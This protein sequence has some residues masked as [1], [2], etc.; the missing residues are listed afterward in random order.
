MGNANEGK[1]TM[2][3]KILA[4]LGADLQGETALKKQSL[5]QVFLL[6]KASPCANLVLAQKFI[7]CAEYLDAYT[8][9][10]D[11][12][13]QIEKGMDAVDGE[14]I[15]E[16]LAKAKTLLGRMC[17]SEI[18]ELSDKKLARRYIEEAASELNWMPAVSDLLAMGM[19][20][21][22]RKKYEEL[23]YMGA[24]N[25]RKGDFYMCLQ[26]VDAFQNL[27]QG[28][29]A[30]VSLSAAL[31]QLTQLPAA[32]Q[33]DAWNA[34]CGLNVKSPETREAINFSYLLAG[35]M[36]GDLGKTYAVCSTGAITKE[37]LATLREQA[38]QNGR[39]DQLDCINA[40]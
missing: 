19:P 8:L 20:A 16:V 30:D 27:K 23:F 28:L 40:R 14:N 3:D 7:E 38:T 21:E 33:G 13:A 29:Q 18:L 9:L 4:N 17:N 39:T 12:C 2:M 1:D 31:M 11:L 24:V 6:S 15:I 22:D 34:L 10:E 37:E 26:S 32:E 35:A 25:L 36:Q 5:G